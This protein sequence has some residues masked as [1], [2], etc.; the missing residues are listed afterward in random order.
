[1]YALVVAKGGP[2]MKET[3]EEV[4]PTDGGGPNASGPGQN[5]AFG[6]PGG[7]ITTGKDGF[8]ELPKGGAGRGGAMMM[9]M[10]GRMRMQA[11]GQT[12]SRLVDMLANQLDRPVTD[13]TDLKGKYDYTLDFAPDENT[14]GMMKGAMMGGPPPG[15]G[16]DGGGPGGGAPPD[17][18]G[19]SLFAA[20]QEQLGL[21]LEAKKGPIDLLVIDHMEKVPTEN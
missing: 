18:Q 15:A 7:K 3:V 6:G 20:V 16:G 14:R 11:N 8:P 17:A 12:M 10:N 21:K 13:M 4:A 2:K 9:V 1:M 5:T 19:P